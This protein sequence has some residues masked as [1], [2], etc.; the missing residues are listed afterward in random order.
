MTPSSNLSLREVSYTPSVPSPLNPSSPD[1]PSSRRS[2]R[3]SNIRVARKMGGQLS[4]T[5]RLMRQKAAAAWRSMT[6]RSVIAG[7]PS[8]HHEINFGVPPSAPSLAPVSAPALTPVAVTIPAPALAAAPAPAPAP[9][10]VPKQGMM[11]RDTRDSTTRN[12]FEQPAIPGAEY[13]DI[14]LEDVEVDT[15]KQP[16]IACEEG[17]QV[18]GMA[19]PSSEIAKYSSYKRAR[20]SKVLTRRRV[21]T[22]VGILCAVGIWTAVRP[23]GPIHGR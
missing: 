12:K 13:H 6:L 19:P 2:R 18:G 1:M 20:H 11:N 10:L 3:G 5:Q 8:I 22:A 15:E 9:V 16:L 4:P 17:R 21:L 7:Y 14:D 23:S